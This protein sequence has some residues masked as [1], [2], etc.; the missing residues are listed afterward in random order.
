MRLRDVVH[1]VEGLGWSLQLWPG[2]EHYLVTVAIHVYI[3][4]FLLLYRV[5]NHLTQKKKNERG[6]DA[7]NTRAGTRIIY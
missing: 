2:P 5:Q 4:N 3:I 1:S 7:L 6:N